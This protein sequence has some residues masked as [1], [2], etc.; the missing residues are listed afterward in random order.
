[1]RRHL[2]QARESEREKGREE[3]DEC[4]Y[5]YSRVPS[6]S[7]R[8]LIRGTRKRGQK[9]GNKARCRD[10]PLRPNNE[11]LALDSR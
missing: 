9:V 2:S 8:K 11:L 5:I 3:R 10:I 4:P 6:L 7:Q 1:M